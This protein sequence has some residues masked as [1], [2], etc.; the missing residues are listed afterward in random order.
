MF[1]IV[2]TETS[3]LTFI[4]IPGIA[5]RGNWFFLQLALGYILGR[6]LVSIFFLPKYFSSGITS[7]YEILGERFN[8]DIQKIASG[9]FLLTRILADGIRFLA[10]AVIVQV[11]TGWSLPVSVIVIGVVTLIYSALGGI[12]TIV[13]VDSFQFV[14]YLAGGL[15]TILYIL[16]QS[17][18]S[19]A[20]I[21]TGLSEAGKTKIF[22]FSGELLKDPYFFK[23]CDRRCVSFFF[24]TWCRSYDGPKSPWYKRS[25]IRTKS[26][27][28]KW[29][30]CYAAI[31]NLLTGWISYFLLL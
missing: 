30:L 10:T 8:K 2:A 19:A 4:S 1:S 31:W 29:H 16:L 11:V 24:I 6:V 20:N 5:Y 14:L 17:D 21:L 3:V 7:I 27:D 13:W 12:R 25:K 18:N 23:C 28:R 15:I 9:I 26:Y 22:N